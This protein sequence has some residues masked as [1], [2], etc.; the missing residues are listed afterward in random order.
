MENYNKE[1]FNI[2]KNE[3]LQKS[4]KIKLDFE[5]YF[6]EVLEITP[7]ILDLIELSKNDETLKSE[8]TKFTNNE[9]I[10]FVTRLIAALTYVKKPT[11]INAVNNLENNINTEN[12]SHQLDELIDDH[13]KGSI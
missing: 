10:T 13:K 6:Q 4:K 7:L 1:I 12:Y 3:I 11:D 9:N 2:T 5:N 8:F